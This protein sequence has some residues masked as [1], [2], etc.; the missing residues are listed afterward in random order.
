MDTQDD[1]LR[2]NTP[3]GWPQFWVA[4]IAAFLVS[5]DATVL[6]AAFGALRQGFP[7]VSA[8]NLS[9]VLNAYTVT[10]AALLVPAGGLADRYGRKRVFLFG[11]AIFLLASA[12]CGLSNTAAQLVAARVLQAASAA[13]LTPASL[14]I[15]LAAFP[16]SKR[17]LM[18]SIWG[19]VGALAAATGPG[20]GALIVDALGWQWAFYLNLPL[21]FVCLWQ[22]RR[23]LVESRT[24]SKVAS[25]DVVGAA[26]LALGIGTLSLAIVQLESP[27]WSHTE[28]AIAGLVGIAALWSF[29]GWILF[30]DRPLIDPALYNCPTY[31]YANLAMLSFGTA[32]ALMFFAF[33]FYLTQIWHYDLPRAGLSVMP[34]PLAVVPT[35]IITG[36]LATRHGYRPYLLIGSLLFTASGFWFLLVPGATPNYLLAWLPGLLL[37]GVAVGMV[38]PSLSG[39]AVSQLSPRHYGVGSAFNQAT[40]Q[41]GGVLGVALTI[42]FLGKDALQRADFTVIYVVHVALALLTGMLCYLIP[43][44]RSAECSSPPRASLSSASDP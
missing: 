31:R 25:F 22:G 38:M 14:S 9:W 16:A 37:S 7:E 20:I 11:A 3:S 43:E 19:A 36:R 33:F 35:A 10:Y 27:D 18:V 21:G 8:A 42:L 32:F 5:L 41:I 23:V 6:F 44:H 39:A 2:T 30:A 34:G 17:A 40:R 28:L 15:V 26:L 24:D 4:S 12:A 29:V 1:A 13:L